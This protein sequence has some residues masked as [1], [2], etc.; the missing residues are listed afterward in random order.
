MKD[1]LDIEMTEMDDEKH[2]SKWSQ[3]VH[4]VADIGVQVKVNEYWIKA[5]FRIIWIIT[6]YEILYFRKERLLH[7]SVT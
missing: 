1:L 2:E 7:L 3:L 6:S 4:T 5:S